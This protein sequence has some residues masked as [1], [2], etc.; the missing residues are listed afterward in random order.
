MIDFPI[1]VGWAA[2][3]FV[4]KR[5]IRHFPLSASSLLRRECQFLP[6]SS[7]KVETMSAKSLTFQLL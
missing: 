6:P 4:A 2:F 3:W 5:R 7:N 1:W